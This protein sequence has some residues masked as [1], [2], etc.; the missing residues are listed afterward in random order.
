MTDVFKAGYSRIPV[1]DRDRNDIVCV[2][3]T[4]DMLFVDTK[5]IY[6]CVHC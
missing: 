3:L 1:Y 5:V 2:I 6:C 4:K